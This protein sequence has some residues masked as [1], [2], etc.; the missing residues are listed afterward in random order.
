MET[1][2]NPFKVLNKRFDRVENLLLELTEP[3]EDLSKKHYSINESADLLGVVPLTI[4][5][6][7]KSGK[8]KASKLGSR[9]FISHNE[10]F[11]SLSEVKSLKYKRS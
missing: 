8:I 4:R 5:N 6:H 7:I 3:K 1:E 10:L 2:T 9:Y 11:D